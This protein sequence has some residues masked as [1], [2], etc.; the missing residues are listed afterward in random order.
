VW[1]KSL[2]GSREDLETPVQGIIEGRRAAL[3]L[4]RSTKLVNRFG[5]ELAKV[6]LSLQNIHDHFVDR[7][8]EI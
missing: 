6:F 7:K 2:A 8:T 3:Q 5:K 1:S 4:G